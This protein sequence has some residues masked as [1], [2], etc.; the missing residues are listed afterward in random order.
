MNWIFLQTL[1][2][3]VS[4]VSTPIFASNYLLES[5]WRDLQDL[6]T[7][8]PL[9]S[10]NFSQKSSTFF[11]EWIMNLRFFS[12]LKR[13]VSNFAF[14]CE[15]LMK[16]C[17]DFATNSRKKWRV[18]LF[19]SNLRKQI[20]KLPKILKSVKIIHY[21]SLL[22]IRVLRRHPTSVYWRY[23]ALISMRWE[24]AIESEPAHTAQAPA[25]RGRR[26]ARAARVEGAFLKRKMILVH[27]GIRF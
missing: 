21:Y 23:R 8:T 19:Q 6:H 25:A 27:D 26:E 11:R 7:F 9:G 14:F 4:A 10:Q 12:F 1:R 16:F 18:S 2:G 3:S 15:F 24:R 5:S 17:P 13:F 22:F 20:R